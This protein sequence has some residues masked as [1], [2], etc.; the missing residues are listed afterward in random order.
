LNLSSASGAILANGEVLSRVSGF[1]EQSHFF[2]PIHRIIFDA[3]GSLL[4]SGKVA[5]PEEVGAVLPIDVDL[6]GLTLSQYLQ[7]LETEAATP[8]EAYNHGRII[9]EFSLRRELIRLGEEITNAAG[10][11]R[12]DISSRVQIEHA[13]KQLKSLSETGGRDHGEPLLPIES[14]QG[15]GLHQFSKALLGAIELAARAFSRTGSGLKTGF[16]DVDRKIAGLQPSELIV[17]A[18]RPGIG[19]TALRDLTDFLLPMLRDAAGRP[20]LRMRSSHASRG[21]TLMV[22]RQRAVSNHE[23]TGGCE[24]YARAAFLR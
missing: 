5:T 6:G 18:S 1:L 22:R 14:Q 24:R 9:Y 3:L 10:D 2:E 7:L 15:H 12:V 8:A 23:A 19:K 16:V 17:L 21:R 4:R 20:L 13:R 11:N